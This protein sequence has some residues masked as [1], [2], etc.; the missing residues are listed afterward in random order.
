MCPLQSIVLNNQ[1]LNHISDLFISLLSLNL[2]KVDGKQPGNLCRTF[3]GSSSREQNKS[4]KA[5][6]PLYAVFH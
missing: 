3:L 1:S 6:K 5:A 4:L 2:L